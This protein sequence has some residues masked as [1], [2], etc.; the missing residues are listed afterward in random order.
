MNPCR[1]CLPSAAG[2]IDPLLSTGF[3][4]TLLG[5][6][7]LAGI[8]DET[9]QGSER[10]RALQGY[11]QITERELD[12]TEQL[13][14]ALYANMSDTSLFK[15]LSLLYFAVASYSEAARRLG[16]DIDGSARAQ[17]ARAF[18]RHSSPRAAGQSHELD[19]QAI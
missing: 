6:T 14:G 5:I 12:A 1:T 9:K 19:F 4:L 3:P 15:K 8:L 17:A 13:V 18:F 16:V 11:A 2:V 10:D 7:R